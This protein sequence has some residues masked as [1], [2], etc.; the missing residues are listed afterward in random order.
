MAGKKDGV[1]ARVVRKE[2]ARFLAGRGAYVG[3]IDLPGLLHLAL[4]RSPFAHARIG[5]IT[6]PA[7]S[8]GAVFAAD[9]LAGVTP[10]VAPCTVPRVRLAAHP[11]LARGK[12]RFAGEPVV[13]CVAPTRALA[14]D[15]ADAVAVE[16]DPLP[17]AV[18][19]DV[20]RA[21]GA[22]R[23]HD[24]WDDNVV[25]ELAMD[26]GAP[27]A[28]V[29]MRQVPVVVTREYRMARQAI[30]PMEGK[31]CLARWDSRLDQLEL[32]TSTQVPHLIRDA[33]C[34]CLGLQERQVRVI[35]PD[36]GGGFG[37]K[38]VLHPE[39]V[40]VAF[41][42]RRLGRP[43]RWIEDRREHLSAAANTR[44]QVYRMTAFA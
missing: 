22:P 44:E 43:V 30:M 5:A 38:S 21:A 7:D 3:D 19:A 17:A 15:L 37:C 23:V 16:F 1:G 35:A 11:V 29:A 26:F 41:L 24:E 9:D 13:A 42:A 2:D 28:L 39:E 12:A 27:D 36:V 6:R 4:V 8:E 34:Q 25:A 14:E 31:G 40:L 32:W 10:M 33:L 20:A 18:E